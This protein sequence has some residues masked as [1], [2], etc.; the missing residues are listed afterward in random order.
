[1]G[2][3]SYEPSVITRVL[4]RGTLEEDQSDGNAMKEEE[5]QR[6]EDTMLL[7]LK[8]ESGT[9]SQGM[10][11]TFRRKARK[12]SLSSIPAY[13]LTLGLLTFRTEKW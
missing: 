3:L 5:R 1:M 4:L 11:V 12:R 9:T 8:M 7:A 10:L 2:R 13:T 6:F